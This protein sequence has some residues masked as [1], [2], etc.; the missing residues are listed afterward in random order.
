MK[1]KKFITVFPRA[2]HCSVSWARWIQSTPS[3]FFKIHF[4]IILLSYVYVFQE[5][6]CCN[7]FELKFCMHFSFPLRWLE[8][9][10]ERGNTLPF[11]GR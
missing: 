2:H 11:T 5:V 3:Y 7:V 9:Y 1:L 10:A 4:N 8:Y 6:S